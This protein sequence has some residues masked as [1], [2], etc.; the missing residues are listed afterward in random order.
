MKLYL[1][2]GGSGRQ[3]LFAYNSFFNSIDK[4]KPVLY[5]P[6]AMD[7]EKYE[8]CY[9]W[10]KREIVYFGVNNFEMV[11]SSL[12]LKKINLLNYSSIFIGGGNTYKLLKE[13]QSNSNLEK[14]KKYLLDGGIVYGGSAGA[15]IFG[16]DIDGCALMD[17]KLEINTKGFNLINGYSLLCHYNKNRLNQNKNYLK[18]YS[19][20]NKLLFLPEE[21]VL[22]VTNKK[23]KFIGEKKYCLFINGDYS[24]RSSANFKKD[25]NR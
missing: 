11:R 10:F 5:I 21:V 9:N 8:K 12:E 19:N 15:I 3:N 20:K 7:E 18:E 25:I 13:L 1:S 4:N 2:G 16:K 6:F 22:L 23:I 24:I 14:I 17:D